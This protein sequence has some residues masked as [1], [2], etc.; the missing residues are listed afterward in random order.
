M[1]AAT[2]TKLRTC[3]YQGGGGSF[4]SVSSLQ[5]PS[6]NPSN[7]IYQRFRVLPRASQR[8]AAVA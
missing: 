6:S 1:I 2:V 5:E 8:W 3:T 7:I 4:S